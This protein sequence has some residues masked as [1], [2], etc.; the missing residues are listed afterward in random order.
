M[1]RNMDSGTERDKRKKKKKRRRKNKDKE[2]N[3][4][5]KKMVSRFVKMRS[6]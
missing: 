4:R 5:E 3:H 1:Q 6:N 2:R